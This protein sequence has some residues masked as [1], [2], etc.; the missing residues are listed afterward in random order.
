MA[1][2]RDVDHRVEE[3]RRTIAR[4]RREIDVLNQRMEEM[5]N[6]DGRWLYM[7]KIWEGIV[8]RRPDFKPP[9]LDIGLAH[10]SLY[11][12]LRSISTCPPES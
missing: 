4:L 6:E 3:Q 5:R 7:P 11:N 10:G 8:R 2:K 1:R 12:F 9:A